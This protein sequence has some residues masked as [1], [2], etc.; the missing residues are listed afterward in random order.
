M[1]VVFEQQARAE[2]RDRFREAQRERERLHVARRAR[3]ERRVERA[4]A[5]A[6]WAR[7]ALLAVQLR[8]GP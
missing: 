4:E 2:A 6:L 1:Y 3:A 5:G 7:S 8:T